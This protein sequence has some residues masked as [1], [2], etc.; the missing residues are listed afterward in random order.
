MENSIAGEN[1]R[2]L[3]HCVLRI[4]SDLGAVS[5]GIA[6][7]E[8]FE[9]HEGRA[10]DDSCS[11]PPKGYTPE[12]L[13]PGARSVVVVAVRI[14]NGV[15]QS[16]LMPLDTTYA[17]GTFGYVHLNRLLNSITYEIAQFLEDRG[18]ISLPLGAC[19][20][21]RCHRESYEAGKTFSPLHGI[22]NLKRAAILA[23]VGQRSRS[24]LVATPHQG[25]RVRLGAV[26]TTADLVANP[27]IE[28][29]PCPPGCRI[30]VDACPMKAITTEGHVNHVRC[31]SDKGR[32]GTTEPEILNE[33][34]RVFPAAGAPFGYLAHEHAA[35][36][37]FGNR[38]C[39]AACMAQ[40][41]LW[42]AG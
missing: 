6:T 24:G 17:F 20:A 16:N 42:K 3:T 26:I 25:L 23:G 4:A 14:P 2:A 5:T 34:N 40:C 10:M 15:L 28:G 30:C 38:V 18:C 31:F 1:P 41:P 12:E 27:M 11:Y 33:M 13:L 35:I 29:I 19:G 21:A 37:G 22:F 36:D 7:T 9:E 8:R 39:R 32:R